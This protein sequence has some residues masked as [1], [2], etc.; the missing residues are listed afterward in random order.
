[1]MKKTVL[2]VAAAFI[3]SA[4]ASLTA[5]AYGWQNSG[6]EWWYGTNA[7]NSDYYRHTWKYIDG[8]WYYFKGDGYMAHDEYIGGIKVGHDGTPYTSPTSPDLYLGGV[9]ICRGDAVFVAH[10]NEYITLRSAPDTAASGITYIPLQSKVTFLE[11]ANTDFSKVEYRGMTG[12]VLSSY[13]AFQEPEAHYGMEVC[14]CVN[15]PLMNTPSGNGA[16]ICRIPCGASVRKLL[17][18]YDNSSAYYLVEYQSETDNGV[19]GYVLK[20]CLRREGSGHYISEDEAVVRAWNQ[21]DSSAEGD[22]TTPAELINDGILYTC[23]DEGSRYFVKFYLA[24]ARANG[25]TGTIFWTY[26]SKDTGAS[27]REY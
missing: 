16:E 3:L 14:N 7:D 8:S 6:G 18:S 5:F 23:S 10:C 13:L 1:M 4:A 25:G 20:S 26:V 22:I 12:Y 21:E 19:T 2:A 15:T 11:K 27:Y 17:W 9:K 24:E